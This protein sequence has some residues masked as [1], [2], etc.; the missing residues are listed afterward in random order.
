MNDELGE[1][2]YSIFPPCK[3]AV[4]T[5]KCAKRILPTNFFD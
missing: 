3:H 4:H 1:L 5:K 2:T